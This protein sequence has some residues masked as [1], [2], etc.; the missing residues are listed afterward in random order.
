MIA[1]AIATISGIVLLVIGLLIKGAIAYFGKK[2]AEHVYEH[3]E[4]YTKRA[5]HYWN[6]DDKEGN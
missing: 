5:K 1:G 3:R 2:G 6:N 4:D